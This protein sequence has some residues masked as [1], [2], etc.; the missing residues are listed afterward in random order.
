[1]SIC[2]AHLAVRA[3]VLRAQH[4]GWCVEMFQALFLVADDIMD[5]SETRRGSPCWYK[6]PHVGL[7]AVND[8]LM[9]ENVMYTELR[10]YYGGHPAYTQLMELFHEAMLVTCIGESL[11]LQTADQP[12][13]AF[14]ARQYTAIVH[15]KTAF[16]SFYL[17]VAAAMLAAGQHRLDADSDLFAQVRH[18]LYEIGYFFQVQDDY[19]DCFGD[20]AVTGKIG[21]DIQDKKCSWLAVQCLERASDEQRQLMERCYG[22]KGDED[23]AAVRALYTEMGVPQLYAAFEERSYEEICAQIKRLPETIPRVIFEQ[24]MDVIY[25]RKH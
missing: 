7:T 3:D 15:N 22:R 18:I 21:T 16:Y 25:R 14:N 9:L 2:V 11:D 1:M 8:S 10:R 24:I 12:I 13:G 6:L 19:L 5:H 17:P 20:P 4:L 23:V